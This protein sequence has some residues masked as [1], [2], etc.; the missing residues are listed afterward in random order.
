[1]A[2]SINKEIVALARDGKW[3]DILSVYED[4]KEHFYPADYATVMSQLVLIRHMR[5]DDPLLRVYQDQK[6]HL[7]PVNYAAVMSQLGRI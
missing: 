6:E 4:Q 7:H 3:K 2:I 5:K 1:M